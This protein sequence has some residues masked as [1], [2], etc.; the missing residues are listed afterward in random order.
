MTKSEFIQQA[1]LGAFKQGFKDPWGEAQSLANAAPAG[2][3]DTATRSAPSSGGGASSGATFPFGANK[4]QPIFGAPEKDL[5]WHAHASVRSVNDP[6]KSRWAE[7]NMAQLAFYI[8]ELERQGF[9]ASEFKQAPQDDGRR[10]PPMQATDP[11][12]DGVPF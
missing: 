4:G 2:T 12:D 9:D 5:R 6:S 8:A 1:C 3:F 11:L 7:S 10:A